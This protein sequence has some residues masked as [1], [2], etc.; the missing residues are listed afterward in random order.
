MFAARGGHTNI[1]RALINAGADV[2]KTNKQGE[3]ALF[4]A[5]KHSKKR[6]ADLLLD[7]KAEP[8]DFKIPR[9]VTN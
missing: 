8:L 9:G 2:H 1:A 7:Q 4:I 6:M 5:T 3:S